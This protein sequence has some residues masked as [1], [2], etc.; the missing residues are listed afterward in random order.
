MQIK[1]I[2]ICQLVSG[3]I[4]GDPEVLISGPS[5]IEEGLEG[6]ISFLANPKY[7]SFAYS[8]KSSVLL[9]GKDFIPKQKLGATLIKVDNVYQSLA[10][11]LSK[12]SRSESMGSGVS[13]LAAVASTATIGQDSQIGPFVQINE[14]AQIGVGV[15]I[16]A[17][18]YIG[19][20]VKIG[21]HSIIYPGVIIYRD[22]QIGKQCTIHANAVIGSDGFGFATSNEGTYDRIAQ[23]GNVV[24]EDHV[25]IG[26]NTC[27]DRATM[28]STIIRKGVKLDNLIQVGHNVEID[29][30]TGIAAQ[31][32]I[33]GS[34]K[35]GKNAMIGGQSGIAGHL[36]IADG[37]KIQAQSGV[38]GNVKKENAMLYGSPAIDYSNYL[39]S[40]AG[41]KQLPDLI[42]KLRALESQVETLKDQI[43]K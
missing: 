8:T 30:N 36:I 9:V 41:F 31:T 29:E 10:L 2:E 26:A 42:K 6:T 3:E 40:Y 23:I 19:D 1:A 5:K 20:G 15:K 17:N 4:E 13:E 34:S 22:C 27:I 32:G 16:M 43:N 12:F 33:A 11:L 28:G 18:A 21:D 35:I 25:E 14:D 38:A 7:E 37:A 24:L 39:K